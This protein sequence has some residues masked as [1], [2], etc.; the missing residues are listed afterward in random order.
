M[1]EAYPKGACNLIVYDSGLVPWPVNVVYCYS[2]ADIKKGNTGFA[3]GV[4]A[5]AA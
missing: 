2:W 1:D 3:L 5:M 4:R